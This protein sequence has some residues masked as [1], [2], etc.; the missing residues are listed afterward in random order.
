[1]GKRDC[2]SI[3]LTFQLSQWDMEGGEEDSN[4]EEEEEREEGEGEGEGGR[5]WKRNKWIYFLLSLIIMLL[6]YR[7]NVQMVLSLISTYL[8]YAD[9]LHPT[10]RHIQRQV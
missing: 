10:Y 3:V 2:G 6:Y 4:E 8:V 1:M 5:E 7:A 9:T